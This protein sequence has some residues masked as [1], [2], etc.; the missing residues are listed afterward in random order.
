MIRENHH[1]EKFSQIPGIKEMRENINIT[2]DTA[3]TGHSVMH[4]LKHG[5]E[6]AKAIGYSIKEKISYGKDV[7][8]VDSPS[9]STR[10]SRSNSADSKLL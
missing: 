3:S 6:G 9:N 5:L 7:Q 8:Q 2:H 1:D 4:G 10:I